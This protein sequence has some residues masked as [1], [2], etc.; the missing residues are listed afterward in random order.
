LREDNERKAME[1]LDLELFEW[2]IIFSHLPDDIET[3]TEIMNR[4]HIET[5]IWNQRFPRQFSQR[6]KLVTNNQTTKKNP[7][8]PTNVVVWFGDIY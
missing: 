4:F 6:A 5:D 8:A 1:S 2:F 7:R 3:L